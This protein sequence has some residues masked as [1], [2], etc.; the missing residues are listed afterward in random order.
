MVQKMV[1]GNISLESGTGVLFTHSE[2]SSKPGISINGDFTL[3]S[4]GEDVVA[5][6]VHTLPLSEEQRRLA[7][8]PVDRCLQT[9]YPQVYQRLEM[10]VKPAGD[11]T[12]LSASGDRIYLRGS[13]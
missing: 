4:Q 8:N 13:A 5:G 7:K 1:L 3:C 6:L 12:W 10:Y 9:D 2:Q 11:G